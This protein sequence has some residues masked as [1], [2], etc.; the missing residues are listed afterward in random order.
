[1]SETHKTERHG[2]SIVIAHLESAGRVVTRSKRKT[3]D[4]V[5]DGLPAEVKCK[6]SPWAKVDFIGL[7]DGQRRALDQGERFILFVVCNLKAVGQEEVIE[8]PSESL[9]Q[10]NFKVESMHYIYGRELRLIANA[11]K[12]APEALGPSL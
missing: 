7:T 1:M 3:F 5:V 9:L 8:I 2:T 6:S 11:S 4:L 12:H 10:A